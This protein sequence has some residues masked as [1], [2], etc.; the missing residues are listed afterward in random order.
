MKPKFFKKILSNGLTVLL[1]KR[2]L[3][4]VSVAFAVKSGGINESIEEK[5]ISHFIE[6]LLYKGTSSRSSQQIAGE[7][8][9]NG[10]ELNGF[11]SELITA[12]WC[13]MPSNHLKIA[14][15]VLSD[16]IKNPLFKEEDIEKERKVIFE[17]I[18]MYKDNPR[19]HVFDEIQKLLY[20]KPLGMS[21]AGTFKTMSSINKKKILNYFEKAYC[22][23]NMIVCVV[24]DFKEK[25]VFGFLEKTFENKKA[26][27]DKID[28]QLKNGVLIEKRKGIDQA[29]LVFAYHVPL[30]KNKKSFAAQV[31]NTLLAGGM[32]S[33]L[34]IEIR[35]K[36]NLAYAVKGDSII[37]KYFA[38]NLIYVGTMKE[39][40]QEIR[41]I[42]LKELEKITKDLSEKELEEIK[43][44]VI[45][46]HKIQMED[47]QGQMVN[48]LLHEIDGDAETLYDFEKNICA[49]KLRDVKDLAKH[50]SKNFSFFALVPEEN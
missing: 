35:E 22:P 18:K 46:N 11:T 47:S 31:L 49:V 16:L 48:L 17:E 39:N 37:N 45:G 5:G 1:E 4:I 15:D 7:I 36:R 43:E 6:H 14:L 2:D 25:E 30:A 50:A 23:S 20:E 27:E 38:Y 19:L 40:V 3:P 28:V 26:K 32:S 10:G 33:R 44:Q 9:K 8:E 42:I 24:G 12:Y 13:K 34:F 41:E 29:N 21:L